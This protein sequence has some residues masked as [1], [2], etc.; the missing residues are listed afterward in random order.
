MN[1]KIS[2]ILE[3]MKALESELEQELSTRREQFRYTLEN[4]KVRFERDILAQQKKF[5]A[6]LLRYIFT[7][8][9]LHVLTAPV[10]YAV[11][12]P[13]VL[14]D[15]MVT[16]YQYVCFPVYGIPRVKRSDYLVFDRHHLA[17]LNLL[18]KMNCFYCS[19]ANGLIP[20]FA[21]VVGRTE[22]YWC[23][24][25][26]ASRMRSVH[27]R[28]RLFSEYGDAEGFRRDLEKIRKDFEEQSG[29]K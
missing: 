17:Y 28:Y 14:L 6:G 27:S 19:Y 8:R 5:R 2:E 13:L 23:P 15:L 20:Y 11:S 7:A 22:Q 10:I 25:K 16:L 1:R 3:R 4:H 26:H 21:E 9:P 29:Q 18:E 12:I 24:I